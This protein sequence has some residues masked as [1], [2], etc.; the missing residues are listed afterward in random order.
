MKNSCKSFLNEI[1][2]CSGCQNYYGESDNGNKLICALHPYGFKDNFCP[3]Y[4]P[5]KHPKYPTLQ[6]IEIPAS[7]I[8]F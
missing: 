2:V 8:P 5:K 7:D 6:E 1:E 4:N 3:D